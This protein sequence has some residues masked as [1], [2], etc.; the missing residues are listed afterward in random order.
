MTHQHGSAMWALWAAWALALAGGIGV[1][2][3]AARIATADAGLACVRASGCEAA[4]P[5]GV[6]TLA[7]GGTALAVIGGLTATALAY[8]HLR[9]DDGPDGHAA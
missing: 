9:Q 1:L 6:T 4:F 2:I 5:S 7:I 8:R 3:A